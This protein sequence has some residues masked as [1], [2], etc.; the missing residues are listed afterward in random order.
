[1]D[2][3]TQAALGAVVGELCLGKKIGN[4]AI[5]YGAIA[6]TIPDLDVFLDHFYNDVE[7]VIMHRSF[8][9]SLVF[10]VFM[11]P[12]LGYLLQRIY[13]R[14]DADF[15]D[16]SWFFFWTIVTHPVL[17]IF[18]GYGTQFLWPFTTYGI[19]LNTISIVDPVFTLPL[20]IGVI[21][22]LFLR[23]TGKKRRWII[24]G[25]LAFSTS[26]LL[27]TCVN[28]LYIQSVA[29]ENMVTQQI[30][31]NKY[32]TSPTL[33]NNILW[34]IV[35]HEENHFLVGYYSLFDQDRKIDFKRIPQKPEL[36]EPYLKDEEVQQLKQFTKG[37]YTL[38]KSDKGIVLNDLRFGPVSGWFDPDQPYIFSFLIRDSKKEFNIERIEVEAPRDMEAFEPLLER[39]KGKKKSD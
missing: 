28:K 30:K 29:K 36:L 31:V 2:S 15:K 38:Q 19:E 5:V 10:A 16:W 13:H 37:F 27:L 32:M 17:D 18:T 39:L 7:A 21:V 4:K 11:A 22:A 1:M 26:Y 12:F 6:G 35:I 14:E 3:V 25:V 24:A 33:L 20:L 23:R 8:S 34:S 9:H